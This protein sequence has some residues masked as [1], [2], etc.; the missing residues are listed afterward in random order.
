MDG[1]SSCFW[2]SSQ[3]GAPTSKGSP[4]APPQ[5]RDLPGEPW[6]P[7]TPSS[8]R[9]GRAGSTHAPLGVTAPMQ[10]PLP[11]FCCSS[12]AVHSCKG[13]GCRTLPGFNHIQVTFSGSNVNNLQPQL[14]RREG[15]TW[16]SWP[17]TGAELGVAAAA[18]KCRGGGAAGHK[19]GG[20]TCHNPKS[21]A[22]YPRPPLNCR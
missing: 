15:T 11:R 8:P 16:P 2:Q 21:S 10:R 20:G 13:G 12:P 5:C 9:H 7:A 19:S 22:G 3:L 17:L 4:A 1:F 18:K 6:G 14:P